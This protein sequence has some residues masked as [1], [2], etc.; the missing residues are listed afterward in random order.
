MNPQTSEVDV[1]QLG[2]ELARTNRALLN[3]L[4]G[5]KGLRRRLADLGMVEETEGDP[6]RV[7]LKP[8][9]RLAG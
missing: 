4:S 1:G 3:R 7:R 5:G 8:S 6:R 9:L 2:S